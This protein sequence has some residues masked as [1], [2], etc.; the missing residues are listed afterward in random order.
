MQYFE[1]VSQSSQWYGRGIETRGDP[2]VTRYGFP[3]L[4]MVCPTVKDMD[5]WLK[6]GDAS[7]NRSYYARKQQ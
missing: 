3:S 2:N 5:K 6:Y 1:V 4:R 7:A